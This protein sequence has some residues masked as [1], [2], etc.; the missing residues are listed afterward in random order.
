MIYVHK[1]H[2]LAQRS[3][4]SFID[5]KDWPILSP[6]KSGYPLWE[7]L[8]RCRQ[9]G[10]SPQIVSVVGDIDSHFRS[11]PTSDDVGFI[12]AGFSI[13]NHNESFIAIPFVERD[14]IIVPANIIVRAGTSIG[15]QAEALIEHIRN[16]FAMV[17]EALATRSGGMAG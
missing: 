1:D 17:D 16:R 10:F 2:P 15:A 5:L 8:G 6:P 9:Y 13:T 14:R 4:V 3:E 7:I 12:V 11:N